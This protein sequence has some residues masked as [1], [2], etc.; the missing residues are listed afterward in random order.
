MSISN[1]GNTQIKT[2]L[3][4]LIEDSPNDLVVQ[5]H[6]QRLGDIKTCKKK[7]IR[8]PKKNNKKI[9]F[10]ENPAQVKNQI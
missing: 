4:C 9:L 8:R 6:Q 7:S 1:L 10:Q 2:I 5:P 3:F